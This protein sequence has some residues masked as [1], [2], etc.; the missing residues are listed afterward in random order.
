MTFAEHAKRIRQIEFELEKADYGLGM[1]RDYE[2]V[3]HLRVLL[4]EAR[5]EALAA[6]LAL[7]EAA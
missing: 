5:E 4:E 7:D 3:K 2:R 1:P 6:I